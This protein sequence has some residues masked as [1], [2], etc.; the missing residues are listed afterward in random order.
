MV[1]RAFFIAGLVLMGVIWCLGELSKISDPTTTDRLSY[2][3]VA[4]LM[5]V[6]MG[7][8]G[9]YLGSAVARGIGI[10]LPQV[11]DKSYSRLLAIEKEFVRVS[12]VIVVGAPAPI[13]IPNYK[14]DLFLNYSFSDERG[15]H[16]CHRRYDNSVSVSKENR[17]DRVLATTTWHFVSS[18]MG[19]IAL[20]QGASYNFHVPFGTDV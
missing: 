5:A 8:L 2:L 16:Y 13:I 1:F 20:P 18:W 17:S 12:K 15:K 7:L 19:L 14:M 9:F 10:F 3:A 6:V 4:L 11:P